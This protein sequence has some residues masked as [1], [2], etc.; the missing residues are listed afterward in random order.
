MFG[1]TDKVEDIDSI[2]GD[3]IGDIE[4]SVSQ[5]EIIYDRGDDINKVGH[6]Y[7]LIEVNVT[8][9]IDLDDTSV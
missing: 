7:H 4:L 1:N 3:N 8:R 2:V 9:G 5:S 6:V